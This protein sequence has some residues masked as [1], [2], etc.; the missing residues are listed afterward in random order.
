MTQ[1]LGIKRHAA[2]H[3]TWFDSTPQGEYSPKTID[4]SQSWKCLQDTCQEAGETLLSYS[5]D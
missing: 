4:Y 5:R 2:R 3:S 1:F